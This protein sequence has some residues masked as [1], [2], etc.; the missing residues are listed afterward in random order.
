[1]SPIRGLA[2]APRPAALGAQDSGSVC[3][4]ANSHPQLSFDLTPREVG[5]EAAERCADKA[6]ASG[7]DRDGARRFVVS[8]LRR[9]GPQSGE[10]LVKAATEHG[11]RPHDGRAFGAVFNAL[12]R[13]KEIVCLRADLPRQAG[14]GTSG[15]RLWAAAGPT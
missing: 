12:S 15:G 1:M 3:A 8:W 9:H 7:F 2:G 4:V 13:R 14:H 5:L 6:E 11:F 10:S